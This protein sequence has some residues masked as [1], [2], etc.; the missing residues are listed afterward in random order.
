MSQDAPLS[1]SSPPE[2]SITI[3]VRSKDNGELHFQLSPSQRLGRVFDRVCTYIDPYNSHNEL[4]FLH[5][6]QR[7]DPNMAPADAG[8]TDGD[9][10]DALPRQSGGQGPLLPLA[11][12]PVTLE[13]LVDEMVSSPWASKA[14]VD[15]GMAA[16]V[17]RALT[18]HIEAALHTGRNVAVPHLG[19]FVVASAIDTRSGREAGFV[20]P[21]FEIVLGRFSGV[22]MRC[23]R[24]APASRGAGA[25]PSLV[26]IQK[27]SGVSRKL[28]YE[29]IRELVRRMGAHMN[30]RARPIKVAFPGLGHL[31]TDGRMQLAFKFERALLESILKDKGGDAERAPEP[32]PPSRFPEGSVEGAVDRLARRCRAED[33][34]R[35]GMVARMSL[36]AWLDE[37]VQAGCEVLGSLPSS[38]LLR[39]LREATYGRS[40]SFI[41]YRAFLEALTDAL[42]DYVAAPP[43]TAKAAAAPK[44]GKDAHAHGHGHGHGHGPAPAQ[45]ASSAAGPHGGDRASIPD[46]ADFAH[47][48]EEVLPTA[49]GA[50]K[51]VVRGRSIGRAKEA[52]GA[53][54]PAPAPP[55][56]PSPRRRP[57]PRPARRTSP[58][59]RT[60]RRRT[61]RWSR[62][63]PTTCGRRSS[64]RRAARRRRATT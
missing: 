64:H 27:E 63:R 10:I 47:V 6:G 18:Q 26:H 7:L 21:F 54:P 11:G 50:G 58:R 17:W 30:A 52:W 42:G 3:R 55:P 49:R 37:A 28:A 53:A 8:L 56:P 44:R 36:E 29:I 1:P 59:T 62:A 12:E 31:V 38:T 19:S 4:V 57:R 46:P 40:K 43:P 61:R 14:G 45:A 16:G 2:G 13:V 35:S 34:S 9:A 60:S 23:L 24:Y 48:E 22:R 32:L 41:E 15:A 5:D 51:S 25:Q 20:R 33:T 39:L